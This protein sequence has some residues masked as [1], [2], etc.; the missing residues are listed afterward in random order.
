MTVLS[1]EVSEV[2]VA[3][4]RRGVSDVGHTATVEALSRGFSRLHAA[5]CFGHFLAANS[6]PLVESFSRLHAARCFG[7]TAR[8]Q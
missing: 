2:S 1:F 3:F 6:E 4:M 7:R 8:K 5:R